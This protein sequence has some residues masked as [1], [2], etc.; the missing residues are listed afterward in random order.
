M[1]INKF[2][3]LMEHKEDE[4]GEKCI[5]VI[6]YIRILRK[7][8]YSTTLYKFNNCSWWGWKGNLWMEG[9]C[10]KWLKYIFQKPMEKMML[11][12]E[13]YDEPLWKL[14]SLPV[15]FLSSSNLLLT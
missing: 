12:L 1:T 15:L 11:K 5:Q 2:H 9:N 14:G 13:N 3:D 6:Y 8:K 4:T 7:K 10:L